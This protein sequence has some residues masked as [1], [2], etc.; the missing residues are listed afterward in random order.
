MTE[1]HVAL[2]SGPEKDQNLLIERPCAPRDSITLLSPP[3][4]TRFRQVVYLVY[5]YDCVVSGLGVT[6]SPYPFNFRFP[7]CRVPSLRSG[8]TCI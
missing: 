6:F 3:S 7:L 1:A 8:S 4:R 2:R 5:H